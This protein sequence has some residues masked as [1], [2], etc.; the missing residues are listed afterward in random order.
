M[1]GSDFGRTLKGNN[2][3]CSKGHAWGRQAMV[4]DGP[5]NGGDLYGHFPDMKM[6]DLG[7]LDVADGR[8]RMIPEVSIDQ[9]AAVAANWF[10]VGSS[11]L[12]AIFPNLGLFDDPLTSSTA[13]MAYLS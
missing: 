1:T 9:Y 2:P 11:E 8:G 7:T 6:G 4:M 3:A 13:N 12:E 5:V 10:S